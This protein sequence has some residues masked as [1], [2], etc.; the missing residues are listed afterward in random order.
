[1]IAK[2]VAMRAKKLSNFAGLLK[3]LMDPQNKNE[4]VGTVVVMNCHSMAA[5]I[6]VLEILNTQS[7]NKRAESD[8]TYHL[9]MSFRAGER[10]D[11]ATLMELESR[12]CAALGYAE[13][14]RISVVHHDTDNL[15]VH[16][17]I[18][19]IH[20][21]KHTI[22]NPYNDYF[23]LGRLCEQLEHDFNLQRDNHEPRKQGAANA[24]DD[25][26]HHAGVESL[27]G[28]IRRECLQQLLDTGSWVELHN[29]MRDNGLM[30]HERGNGLVIGAIDGPT[31]KA[32]SV[33]RAL[34]KSRLEAL[35]G[36]FAT[37]TTD[38]AIVSSTG[39]E[40]E[41][42]TR[43]YRPQ[44]MRSSRDTVPLYALY[45]QEQH[46]VVKVRKDQWAMVRERTDHLLAA[47]KRKGRLKRAAIK[48]LSGDRWSKSILYTA[49]SKTLLAEIEQ[50]NLG[51]L[52]EREQI[53]HSHK[54]SA[55]AD[56]LCAQARVGND[57]AL[58]ALRARPGAQGLT[59]NT[60]AGQRRR[61]AVRLLA[62]DGITKHGT[63]IVQAGAALLRDDGRKL[64]VSGNLGQGGLQS[65]LRVAMDLYGDCI[66]AEGSPHFIEQV[67]RAAALGRLPLQFDDTAQERHRVELLQLP[68]K[69]NGHEPERQ[70]GYRPAAA[71]SIR[72]G[73]APAPDGGADTGHA[74][75]D[76]GGIGRRPPPASQ[77]RLRNLSALGM[78]HFAEGTAMLLP[79]DVSGHM[80]QQ[81]AAAD[82]SLRRTTPRLGA[83]KQKRIGGVKQRD[84]GRCPPCP[85]VP[86]P[87]ELSAIDAVRH[88]R[89][90]RH[91]PD[92]QFAPPKTRGVAAA[93]NFTAQTQR[94]VEA[95]SAAL[96]YVFER[97]QKRLMLQDIPEHRAYDGYQG[98]TVFAGLREIDGQRLALLKHEDVILVL[99]V[100]DATARR[101]KLLALGDPVTIARGGS[102]KA[103][104]RSR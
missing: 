90:D 41:A 14:Q 51:Y 91:A 100:A 60:L 17:T 102:I 75:P 104:G 98:H 69:E 66:H 49:T 11:D 68:I 70:R 1:M 92:A 79:R 65:A 42:P 96:K 63:V 31:V 54:R 10:P 16:I 4:R 30:L 56:W 103:K 87:I 83:A 95:L 33:D 78:V 26:E 34:S 99:P 74:K 7:F 28:W 45:R 35:M 84:L 15:H 38:Q 12:L 73:G 27:L 85:P 25:M 50:I 89:P 97:E 20:P 22:H 47:A 55:W 48:L 2:H 6:A 67:V 52:K 8:N 101:L 76:V 43:S 53:R 3:Y 9:V 61:D 81:G 40:S 93:P 86:A 57:E 37:A 21:R 44:P 64:Q 77:H 36:P 94:T 18:N 32:S 29:A 59:G 19:K 72:R 24:A 23:K 80:E 58:Q 82:H 46:S 62:V 71:G 13:H 88:A 39:S 5:E